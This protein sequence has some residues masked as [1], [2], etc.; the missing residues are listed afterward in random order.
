MG[1]TFARRLIR[2]TLMAFMIVVLAFLILPMLVIV[3][4]SFSDGKYLNFP[5]ATYSTRWYNEIWSSHYPT[6]FVNSLKIGFPSAS[7]AVA[8]GTLAALGVVRGKPRH[9]RFISGL[10]IAPFT[11]PQIILAIGLVG[12]FAKLSLVGTYWAAILGHAI[13]STSLVFLSVSASLRSYDPSFEMAAMTLGANWWKTFWHITFPMI[14]MG[15]LVGG[16][17][18]FSFSFDEIILALFLTSSQTIT[19]PKQLYSELRFNVTPLIA[20]VS[21]IIVAL[22][23]LFLGL[24]ALIQ[25]RSRRNAQ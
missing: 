4:L 17:L 18:A 23:L 16:I 25:L 7:L 6:A 20:S 9:A 8:A 13:A 11:L 5:P 15:M 22:S 21:V 3:P 24:V 19:L 1:W 10:V 2:L 14:R 12:I